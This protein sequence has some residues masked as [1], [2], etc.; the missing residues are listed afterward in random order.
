VWEQTG[1]RLLTDHATCDTLACGRKAGDA[2][3]KT[4]EEEWP[5]YTAS[6]ARHLAESNE[7]RE[8]GSAMQSLMKGVS[9]EGEERI[10]SAAPEPLRQQFVNAI[11]EAGDDP[12][13]HRMLSLMLAA[14]D[15]AAAARHRDEA[16]RLGLGMPAPQRP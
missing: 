14:T 16:A 4:F 5:G 1:K 3:W 2:P 9:D 6:V 10:I 7:R 12:W 13:L 11:P 15:P 8:I